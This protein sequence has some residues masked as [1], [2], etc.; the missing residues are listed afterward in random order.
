LGHDL[1]RERLPENGEGHFRQEG[2]VRPRHGAFLPHRVGLPWYL[3][4]FIHTHIYP[5]PMDTSLSHRHV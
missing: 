5:I 1:G 3:L 4:R 2:H